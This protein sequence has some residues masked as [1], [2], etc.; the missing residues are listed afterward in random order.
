MTQVSAN[1]R[2]V[3][4]DGTFTHLGLELIAALLR[5]IA[6]LEARIAVLETP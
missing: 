2:Y 1:A 6:A 3:K 4:P 5:E